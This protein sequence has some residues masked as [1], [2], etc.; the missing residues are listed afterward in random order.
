[1]ASASVI[2]PVLNGE[3]MLPRCLNSVLK[4][5]FVVPPEIIVVDDGS[6]DRSLEKVKDTVG[7]RENV[8]IISHPTNQGLSRTL[9][10]GIK[11]ARGE[12]V[13]IVHQDCEMMDK[14]YLKKAIASLESNPEVAAVT[15]HR[16]YHLDGLSDEEKFF[17]V[18]NG[19]ISEMDGE[20]PESEDV[21]FTEH[22]CD[23][24]RKSLVESIGGFPNDRF[25]SSG[26]DQVLSSRLRD[27]GYKLVRLGSISYSLGFGNKESTISGI[28]HKLFVYGKTQ[29]GVLVNQRRSSLKGLSKTRALTGRAINRV[30]MLA[31]GAVF[32]AGILLS[33]AS[34]YFILL[35]V[36]T[37]ASRVLIYARRLAKVHGKIRFA[38]MGPLL[39]ITY[40]IGFLEGTIISAA[41]GKL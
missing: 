39:D 29:A 2:V 33:V 26:E 25:R 38:I 24:F 27:R 34:P 40:M 20:P 12:F 35:S 37:A 30:E 18:A 7:N 11:E 3:N 10:E 8:R 9:N 15:G 23:L 22:K 13:Q 28:L 19:H 4:Q 21:T 17:V 32:V 1:M 6:T 14:D 31:T 16:V 41:G 36:A 5:E